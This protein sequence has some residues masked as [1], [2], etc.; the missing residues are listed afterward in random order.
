[1]VVFP[2]CKINL[3]LNIISKR[4]DGYH[5]IETVFYPLNITDALEIIN[6]KK[7]EAGSNIQFSAGGIKIDGALENNLCIK[8]YQLLKKKFPQLP[9][10]KMHLLKNI[11]IGAGLG[12][13]SA[14][15]AFT[16]LLLNKK[17]NLSL[18]ISQLV[19]F[20]SVLGSD[21]P[22]FISGK[23]S[24]AQGRG[25]ILEPINLNLSAYKFCIV[26]PGIH[27]N[28]GWAFAQIKAAGH[29]LGIAQIIKQPVETWKSKLINDFEAP[30]LQYYPQ[31]HFIKEELYKQGALYAA[32][33]GSGSTFF[34][35]FNKEQKI[36]TGHWPAEYYVKEVFGV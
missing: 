35:I 17:F 28:T 14:N 33:S 31:L 32:M 25:E 13:G 27:I 20:A 15:G 36:F 26:N 34:G 29:S 3:G 2:N 30:V 9:A 6:D 19:N 24:Y 16:L 11:P 10:I 4:N 5:N 7:P 22:F 21:C 23:P 8:A 18:S 1:M 12:G